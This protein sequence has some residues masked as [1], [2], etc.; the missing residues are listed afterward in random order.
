MGTAL[1]TPDMLMDEANKHL[2]LAKQ[3]REL[4]KSMMNGHAPAISAASQRRRNSESAKPRRGRGGSRGTPSGLRE[5]QIEKV[6]IEAD[7][8]LSVK[9]IVSRTRM[10]KGSVDGAIRR[11]PDV[12]RVGRG[13]YA[14]KGDSSAA[15]SNS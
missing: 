3:Y 12:V 4:A 11:V 9:Q 10:P 14:L 7:G 2:E 6:F 13:L 1:L 5:R 15:D 8:P